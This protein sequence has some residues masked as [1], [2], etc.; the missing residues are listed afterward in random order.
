MQLALLLLISF[1]PP[2]ITFLIMILCSRKK[3][4]I[5]SRMINTLSLNEEKGLFKQGALWLSLFIPFGWFLSFGITAWYEYSLSL[6]AEGFKK[7]LEISTLPLALLAIGLP[8]S[9]LVAR[10]H[11]THQTA[12]QISLSKEKNNIDAF[13]SHRKE[14]YSFFDRFPDLNYLGVFEASFK[15]HPSLYTTLYSGTPEQGAP[16]LN[17]DKLQEMLKEITKIRDNLNNLFV[18]SVVEVQREEYLF[19]CHT[20]LNLSIEI[21]DTS[22][23]KQLITKGFEGKYS[24][25]S[26]SGFTRTLG[27]TSTEVIA[28]YRYMREYMMNICLCVGHKHTFL[29]QGY[30]HIDIDISFLTINPKGPAVE[31]VIQHLMTT[32]I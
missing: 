14:F 11:A 32:E 5:K 27:R 29:H 31:R 20:I 28:A 23:R 2:L 13:Y 8:A 17:I 25:T 10:F 7:F 22:I 6:N 26:G 4:S 12:R 18:E 16:K 19:A 9:V 3:G 24:N 21:A 15:V 30:E 1:A